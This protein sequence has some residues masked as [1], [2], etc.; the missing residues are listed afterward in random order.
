PEQ[1]GKYTVEIFEETGT[2]SNISDEHNVNWMSVLDD[3]SEENITISP[4][5]NNG[6][7]NLNINTELKGQV[8]FNIYDIKGQKVFTQKAVINSKNY[9]KNFSLPNLI[10]GVYIFSIKTSTKELNKK[11][12]IE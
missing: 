9:V 7:F 8:E 4:N 2:C 11:F 3:I 10:D 1:D 6:N 12:I 5:P